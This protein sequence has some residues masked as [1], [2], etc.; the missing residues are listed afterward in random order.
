MSRDGGPTP[1]TAA[2]SAYPGAM[3][4]PDSL[5]AGPRTSALGT[6]HEPAVPT[7]VV[8]AGSLV[9]GFA[10][11]QATEVRALGGAVLVVGALWCG[12]HWVRRRPATG[13]LLL[14]GYA[15]GFVG[16]HLLARE[17]GAW[18]SVLTVAGAVGAASWVAS[19]RRG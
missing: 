17:I 14:L 10:V 1:G 2:A 9:V 6:R 5:A 12:R 11:A 15:G 18:P 3:G 13:V 4:R 19:D 8:A 7:S 16:S